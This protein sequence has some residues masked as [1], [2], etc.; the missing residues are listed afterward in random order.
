M[1]RS[2]FSRLLAAIIVSVIL[3]AIF[4][5]VGHLDSTTAQQYY[6]RAKQFH[7]EPFLLHAAIY[8]ML[9]VFFVACVEMIASVIRGD[10][11][12]RP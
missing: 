3:A 7:S 8:A 9:G 2:V 6:D 4:D 5:R 1:N 12:N 10:W 11:R